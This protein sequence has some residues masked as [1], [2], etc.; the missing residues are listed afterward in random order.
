MIGKIAFYPTKK[1]IFVKDSS[2]VF[3]FDDKDV[4][5]SDRMSQFIMYT[6]IRKDEFDRLCWSI[7]DVEISSS[8]SSIY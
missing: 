2:L 7:W 6:G 3:L 8:T 5:L 1:N 4:S